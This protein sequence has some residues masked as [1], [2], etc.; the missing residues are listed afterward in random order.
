M[1]KIKSETF[2]FLFVFFN[3]FFLYA[4]SDSASK[5]S[6][7]IEMEN[8][9]MEA[10]CSQDNQNENNTNSN[11]N[12]T[13]S[14]SPISSPTAKPTFSS[15]YS[16]DKDTIKHSENETSEDK[17][18]KSE[19]DKKITELQKCINEKETE[20]TR[21]IKQQVEEIRK[22]MK[23][24]EK[25]AGIDESEL[26]ESELE[27]INN[28]KNEIAVNQKK[29]AELTDELSTMYENMSDLY[30]KLENTGDPV[31]VST[32]RFVAKY[33]DYVAEDFLNKFSVNRKLSYGNYSESFGNNWSCS[34][35]SRIIRCNYE[36][37]SKKCDVYKIILQKIQL[38]EE[39]ANS[40]LNLYGNINSEITNYYYKALKLEEKYKNDIDELNKL[41]NIHKKL[42]EMNKYVTYGKYSDKKNYYGFDNLLIF[43]DDSGIGHY[44]QYLGNGEWGL[45]GGVSRDVVKIKEMNE[46]GYNTGGLFSLGGYELIYEN[47]DKI[48]F[49]R[50]GVIEKKIDRNLNET[51][52]KNKDGRVY[53]VEL[54]TGEVLKINRNEKKYVTSIVGDVSG[55]TSY[56][57]NENYLSKVIDNKGIVIGYNYNADGDLK[58][59]IKSDDAKIK[60]DYDYSP[61]LNH[62]VCTSVTNENNVVEKFNLDYENKTMKHTCYDSRIESYKFDDFGNTIFYTDK[63]NNCMSINRNEDGLIESISNNKKNKKFLYDEKQRPVAI[64]YDDSSKEIIKYND[65]GFISE[66]V[67]RDGMSNSYEYDIYGNVIKSMFCNTVCGTYSYYP[68]GL[69]KSCHENESDIE[70]KYNNFGSLIEKTKKLKNGEIIK[71]KW[72]YDE[73]NRPIEY[74]FNNKDS[75]KYSYEDNKEIKL[76]EKAKIIRSYDKRN[77]LVKES[78]EELSTGIKYTKENIYDSVGNITAVY[79]NKKLLS[80]Y[81]YFNNNVLKSF[82]VWNNP[83]ESD[84]DLLLG[85]KVEYEY[86]NSWEKISEI[87]SVLNKNKEIENKITCKIKYENDGNNKKIT[88]KKYMS[89]PVTKIYD[90]NG[91]LKKE[92][93]SDGTYTKYNY[94]K[95]GR[96]L[97]IIKSN[98]ETYKYNYK[99]EG[100]YNILYENRFG[101]KMLY[102]F[103]KYKQLKSVKDYYGY[104]IVYN[105]NSDG[106]LVFEDGPYYK[107]SNQYDK[108][109]RNTYYCL[110]DSYNNIIYE[111]STVYNDE[112]GEKKVLVDKNILSVE[113]YD[114]WNR[115]TE[116]QNLKGHYYFEYD[117]LGNCKKISDCFGNCIEKEYSPLGEV[118]LE[119]Y[120]D[121]TRKSI[122]YNV[123]GFVEEILSNDEIIS[124]FEYGDDYISGNCL[125][126]INNIKI[127][128]G[129]KRVSV[130]NYDTGNIIIDSKDN[131]KCC[132]SDDYKNMYTYEFGIAGNKIS[133][134]NPNGYISRANYDHIGRLIRK[135]DFSGKIQEYEYDEKNNKQ[136]IKCEN[137]NKIEITKNPL[138]YITN[139]NT[140]EYSLEY[141]YDKCGNLISEYSPKTDSLVEYE[142]D[143]FSRCIKKSGNNFSFKYSYDEMSRLSKVEDELSG[144]WISFECDNLSR[145]NKIKYSNGFETR[146]GYTESGKKEYSVTSNKFGL[147][148]FAEY[149]LYD[150]NGKIE[151]VTDKDGN[152]TKY[153]YDKRGRLI[154]TNYPYREEL[155]NNYIR[156]ANECGYFDKNTKITLDKIKLSQKDI[157]RINKVYEKAG[158]KA[159]TNLN[160]NQFCWLEEYSYNNN[161]SLI[162]VNNP[163]GE[164][165]YEYD[166]LNRLISKNYGLTNDNGIKL[167]WSRSNNL[168][169]ILNK[170]NKI[171]FIYGEQNRPVMI[172]R[173]D[174]LSGEKDIIEFIYDGLG[175]R[176]FEKQN[177]KNI[178]YIYDGLS[179]QLLSKQYITSNDF[180][181]SVYSDKLNVRND[182]IRNINSED[183]DIYSEYKILNNE[184]YTPYGEVKNT[185]YEKEENDKKVHEDSRPFSILAFGNKPLI[186]NHTDGTKNNCAETS[187]LLDDFRNNIIGI[188]KSDSDSITICN[189]DT[190]KNLINDNLCQSYYDTLHTELESIDFFQIGYRDYIP[191]L[192][193]FTTEDPIHSGKNWYAYCAGDPINFNDTNGCAKKS[194]SNSENNLFYSEICAYLNFNE[195]DYHEAIDNGESYM[196]MDKQLDCADTSAFLNYSAAKN[197]GLDITSDCVEKFAVCYDNDDVKGAKDAVSSKMVSNGVVSRKVCD[198]VDS[199]LLDRVPD[200]SRELKR[201]ENV[202]ENLSNP[203]IITPGSVL[204]WKNSEYNSPD[205]PEHCGHTATVLSREFDEKGNIVG[206]ILMEGHTGGEKTEIKY[207]SVKDWKN[208]P[209]VENYWGEF[210]GVYEMENWD[211]KEKKKECVKS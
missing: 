149:I 96:L 170:K 197:A 101:A 19:K 66:V 42:T 130:S 74:I 173:N 88:K 159:F 117:C 1:F 179:T 50:Y 163:C 59:I 145:V 3:I 70:F 118:I 157:T 61:I 6:Y 78:T 153:E 167:K 199:E 162:A 15:G 147:V 40:F 196:G 121:G 33:T 69:I 165:I 29:I 131:N 31:D 91:K 169:E 49:N 44:F 38:I 203:E 80:E 111:Y 134:Q 187:F 2:I 192:K 41:I 55:E 194:Y 180:I 16:S 132:V 109:G 198:G 177:G 18:N 105:Y 36:D 63:N 32:G 200:N 17:N 142:Y 22:L 14:H 103:D 164:I 156:E 84:N 77:R 137:G 73:N 51:L 201:R 124:S 108:K 76:S 138:G 139:L 107:I 127:A 45:V 82:T 146:K 39:A 46:N 75:I 64:V 35:D 89:F 211:T 155:K 93:Y 141:K 150:S 210:A 112:I 47:G 185:P 26:E 60:I 184:D 58:E 5:I 140:K 204:V 90:E 205:A 188:I 158:V 174:L 34:L 4:D 143:Q 154:S 9:R 24:N 83:D 181:S 27:K 209:S 23:M 10:L 189:F 136:I 7:S 128:S 161:G 94:S 206:F 56:F 166:C 195:L 129:G 172:I 48:I 72:L 110:R 208:E 86:N 176:I 54:K 144:N 116:S 178:E 186:I 57:Y 191:S 37:F 151:M 119:R 21:K 202:L 115:L 122:K 190:W 175:R 125:G 207:M 65:L 171:S 12:S 25:I 52:F 79:I 120:P 95:A 99:T 133:E 11:F 193:C 106:Y 160:T 68:N 81:E 62:N 43:V 113:Y 104:T 98:N 114:I 30:I 183:Y 182:N 168:E 13:Y 28:K 71:Y 53:E 97:S 87:R 102:S 152:I 135:E 126:N 67:D 100:G 92:E 20:V 123:L 148:I 85:Y 8:K